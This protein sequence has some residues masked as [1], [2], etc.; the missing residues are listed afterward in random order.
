MNFLAEV[1]KWGFDLLWPNNN[2]VI[3]IGGLAK[4]I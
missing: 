2:H 1:D 4:Y 3:W